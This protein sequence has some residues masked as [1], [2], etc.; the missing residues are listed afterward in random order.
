MNPY[1]SYT[2][3]SHQTSHGIRRRQ[4]YGLNFLVA[5]GTFDEGKSGKGVLFSPSP[6]FPAS[7]F[8]AMIY[9]DNNATTRVA[10]R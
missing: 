6:I 10:P 3:A 1:A 2:V 9:L 5:D 7:R 8:P 4:H